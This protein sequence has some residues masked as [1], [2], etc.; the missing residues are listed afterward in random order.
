MNNYEFDLKTNIMYLKG[1]GPRKAELLNKINIFTF[2]DFLTHY[3]VKYED[4]RE[5][6]SI[7]NLDPDTVAIVVGHISNI[8]FPSS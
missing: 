1:I 8:N 2:Y 6:T 7:V 4:E 3:P 5:V